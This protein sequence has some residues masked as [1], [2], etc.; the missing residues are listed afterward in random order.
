MPITTKGYKP[1]VLLPPQKFDKTERDP[2]R[3][4]V[5]PLYDEWLMEHPEPTTNPEIFDRVLRELLIPQRN[6]SGSFSASSAGYC[7]RR[8][9]LSFLG[10]PK[11]PI[12]SPRGIR[13]FQNGTYVHLRTQVALLSAGI[14]DD[15][16]YTIESSRFSSPVRA[17]LDGLGVARRGLYK[18]LRFG[19]EVKGAMSF[20]YA[21]QDR[22]GVPLEKTRKQVAMQMLLAGYEVWS[23]FNENKDTQETAEFVIERNEDEVKDAELELR[24]LTRSIDIQKLHPMLAGCVKKNKTGEY[25]KCPYGTDEGACVHAGNWPRKV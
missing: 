12:D 2:E 21:S 18:G 6:R 14:I 5:S 13:I 9:E 19:L 7:K 15:I 10:L 25:F 1:G 17:T 20:S 23:V 24:E 8:Q 11:I 3:L 22:S 4:I 16:E